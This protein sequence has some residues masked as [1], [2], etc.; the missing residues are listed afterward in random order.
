MSKKFSLLKFLIIILF[1]TFLNFDFFIFKYHF[2]NNQPN[3]FLFSLKTDYFQF[4]K[5]K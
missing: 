2:R 5:Q 1:F 4:I 3:I